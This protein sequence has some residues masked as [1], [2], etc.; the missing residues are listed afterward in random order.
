MTLLI[1][2]TRIRLSVLCSSVAVLLSTSVHCKDISSQSIGILLLAKCPDA[3]SSHRKLKKLKLI[4]MRKTNKKLPAAC[5]QFSVTACGPGKGRDHCSRIYAPVSMVTCA[6]FCRSV[7][8]R[9]IMTHYTVGLFAQF[10]RLSIR[11]SKAFK[12]LVELTKAVFLK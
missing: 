6:C 7:Y 2:I 4:I 9:N 5:C 3:V 1:S 10:L 12:L 11:K 8:Y